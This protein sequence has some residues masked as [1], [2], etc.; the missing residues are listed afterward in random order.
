M[1]KG[2]KCTD[3]GRKF[4]GERRQPCSEQFLTMLRQKIP[5]SAVCC[6]DFVH[7]VCSAKL[8]RE[9]GGDKHT[10]RQVCTF[11]NYCQHAATLWYNNTR[12]QIFCTLLALMFF[13]CDP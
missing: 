8:W 12:S 6:L 3:C 1:G 7:E 2:L 4:R 9:Y 11:S 10:K 5:E 13:V